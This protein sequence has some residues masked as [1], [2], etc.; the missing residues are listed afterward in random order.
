M[1]RL[2]RLIQLGQAN[3][4]LAFDEALARRVMVANAEYACDGSIGRQQGDPVFEEVTEGRQKNAGYSACAD[5]VHWCLRRAGLRDEA[6]LNRNDDDGEV[7]WRTAV[8]ISRLATLSACFTRSSAK[9]F[10]ARP[11]D[12][13]LIGEGGDEHIFIVATITLAEGRTVVSSYDYG[14][15]FGGKHAGQKRLR[16][17]TERRGRLYL[18]SRTLP[19]RPV[20]G[21]VDTAALLKRYFDRSELAACEVPDDFVGG[22]P[23]DNPY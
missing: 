21:H 23:S 12:A 10:T 19:G 3:D 14:Q 18:F 1:S 4:P 9:T 6:I 8:N 15:F 20:V 5:L 22:L 7:P 11:G 2:S 16:Q 13:V 17:T